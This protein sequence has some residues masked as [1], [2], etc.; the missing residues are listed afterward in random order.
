[1]LPSTAQSIGLENQLG[2]LNHPQWNQSIF[3][4]APEHERYYESSKGHVA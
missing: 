1:M 3:L 2:L 4:I